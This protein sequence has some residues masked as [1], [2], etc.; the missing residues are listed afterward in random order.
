MRRFV[1]LFEREL[2]AT[3][4]SFGVYAL[5]AAFMAITAFCFQWALAGWG[6]DMTM[7]LGAIHVWLLL[8]AMFV[9][10]LLTMR[11]FAE[12][13]RS[14]S[15]ELLMT[16]PVTDLQVVSAKYAGSVAV[17]IAF[18]LPVWLC[19]L[20]LA[21]FFGAAPDWGQ[22]VAVT[23]GL[24]DVG[25]LLLAMGTLASALTSAQ[26][27]AGLLGFVG[28]AVLWSVGLCRAFFPSD[29]WP[30][31]MLTWMSLDLHVRSS[32]FGILDLRHVVYELGLAALLL[33]W[34]VRIVEARKWR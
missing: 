24:L 3:F 34:T 9:A 4:H 18:M 21:L 27:W 11:S 23:G 30:H 32:A 33:F 29:S 13:K 2:G 16:A 1:L 26:I 22:L 6:Y 7:A 12:E 31:R 5:F 20:V 25:L 17:F 15:F 19:H 10:P 14:G 28:N 8:L